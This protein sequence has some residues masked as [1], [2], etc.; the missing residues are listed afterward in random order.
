LK[1]DPD[2]IEGFEKFLPVNDPKKA[3]GEGDGLERDMV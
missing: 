3:E 1:D 2:L